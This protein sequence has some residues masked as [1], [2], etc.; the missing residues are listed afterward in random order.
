ML[1]RIAL[2]ILP[3]QASS[4]PC[5]WLFSASKQT[6]EERH[7]H[8]GSQRFEELQIMKF[9]WQNTVPDLAAWN[10]AQV[11]D[12]NSECLQDLLDGDRKN[13]EFEQGEEKMVVDY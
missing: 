6:A 4:V 11:E 10:S 9:A 12:V 13:A 8:L 1:V 2:D 3:A 5:E 7:A